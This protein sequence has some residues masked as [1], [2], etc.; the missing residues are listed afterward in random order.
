LVAD[1]RPDVKPSSVVGILESGQHFKKII[2]R[3]ALP[4]GNALHSLGAGELGEDLRDIIRH[5]PLLDA[6]FAQDLPNEDIKIE[7]G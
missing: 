4:F 3:T 6:G 7:M 1:M 5:S 2:Q